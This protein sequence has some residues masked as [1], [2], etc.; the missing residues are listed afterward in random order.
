MYCG[1]CGAEIREGLHFC[2]SCGE[3]QPYVPQEA[4]R[5]VPSEDYDDGS[6]FRGVAK[7]GCGLTILA[8]VILIVLMLVIGG[9]YALFT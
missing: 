4:I 2:E 8:P 1:K 9:I 3:R 6:A 5:Q 7:M